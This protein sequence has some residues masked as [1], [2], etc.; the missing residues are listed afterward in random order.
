MKKQPQIYIIAGP[1][2][3]GKTTF[4]RK[5]LPLYARCNNFINADLIAGGL[6][7]FS[8]RSAAIKAGK[9]LLNEI[10]AFAEKKADFAFETTLSGKSYIPFL[11]RQ[12]VRGYSIHLFFLWVSSVDLAIARIKDRVA[13]G[14][15][16]VEEPDIRRRYSR[17][18]HNFLKLYKPFLDSWYLF[19]NSTE[20]PHLI[21]KGQGEFLTIDDKEI[22]TKISGENYGKKRFVAD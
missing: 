19:D 13:A 4:A 9:L 18:I 15:H 7:P 17:S 11:R 21:G 6:S 22:F 5:F 8:P 3:A 1:N 12:K 14:G 20:T 10:H 2:G 16:N